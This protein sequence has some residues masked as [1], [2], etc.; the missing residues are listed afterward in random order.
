MLFEEC[1]EFVGKIVLVDSLAM[2]VGCVLLNGL[3]G[4]FRC[5]TSHECY[6]GDF[7]ILFI[8]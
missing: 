8:N 7:W 3:L 1:G 4:C 6:V 5:D 2:G